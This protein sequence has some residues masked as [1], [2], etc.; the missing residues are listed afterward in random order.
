MSN[1]TVSS[2]AEKIA[3]ARTIRQLME[4]WQ[5]EPHELATRG[6]AAPEPLAPPAEV[7]PKYRHPVTGETWD[8]QGSQPQWLRD[9][10]LKEGLLVE[11]LR[12]GEP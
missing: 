2:S 12:I 5:I 3:V 1:T 11:E 4:F 10:L 7:Q 6:R 8:G 9:A